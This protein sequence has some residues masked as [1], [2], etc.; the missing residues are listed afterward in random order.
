MPKFDINVG[1]WVVFNALGATRRAKVLDALWR[2][3]TQEDVYLVNFYGLMILNGKDILS[4]T[5]AAEYTGWD[6]GEWVYPG[7]KVAK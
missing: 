3:A 4:V 1:D 2:K 7:K 6:G 5:P